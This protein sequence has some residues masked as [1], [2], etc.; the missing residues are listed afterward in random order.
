VTDPFAGKGTNWFLFMNLRPSSRFQSD[1]NIITTDFYDPRI[2]QPLFDV[3]IGRARTTFQF[4]DR[5]VLRNILEYNTFDRTLGG[6]FL[7]TYRINSG[8]VF[9]VGVDDRYRQENRINDLI[10][11]TSAFR[12]TNRAIFTKL[13][14]LFRY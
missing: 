3:K 9:Y 2:D 11:S 5:F 4:T 1:I 8:T 7:L 10:Y 6:N 12:R 14:Y 13:Q